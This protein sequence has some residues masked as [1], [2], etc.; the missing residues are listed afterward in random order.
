MDASLPYLAEDHALEDS[1]L[2]QGHRPEVCHEKSAVE[3]P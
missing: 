3:P 2:C 1:M